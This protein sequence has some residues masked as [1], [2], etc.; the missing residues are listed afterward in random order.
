M[1]LI[2]LWRKEWRSNEIVQVSSSPSGWDSMRR[3][4]FNGEYTINVRSGKSGEL[5]ESRN[6][7]IANKNCIQMKEQDFGLIWIQNFQ[8]QLFSLN[9]LRSL[10]QDNLI[11]DGDF[12]DDELSS[13]WQING[14]YKLHWDGYL[15]NGLLLHDHSEGSTR[16]FINFYYLVIV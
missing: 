14:D 13:E 8:Y 12:D 7:S 9:H 4:L 2:N 10:E 1:A 3:N 11:E 15:R 16:F 5:V 6:I